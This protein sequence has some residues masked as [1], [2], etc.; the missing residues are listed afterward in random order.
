MLLTIGGILH[1][2]KKAKKGINAENSGGEMYHK[3]EL[4]GESLVLPPVQSSGEVSEI[5]RSEL[6]A[7]ESVISE[8]D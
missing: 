5:I 4:H 1:Y 7:R 6:P 8:L 3:P 2:R